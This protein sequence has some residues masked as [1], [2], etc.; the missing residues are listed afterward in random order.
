MLPWTNQFY[1][2]LHTLSLYK[3]TTYI[4]IDGICNAI[5]ELQ[6]IIPC[7]E[8][9]LHY[10]DF[11]KNNNLKA[12]IESDARFGFFK[13]SVDLHNNINMKTNRPELSFEE[14]LKIWNP[15]FG[16]S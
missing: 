11:V 3:H 5:W 12:Y 7:H 8:C 1:S 10:I 13:W 14:A 2:F 9:K 16:K 4:D 15:V 6:H